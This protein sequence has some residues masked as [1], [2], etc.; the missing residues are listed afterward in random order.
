MCITYWQAWERNYVDKD[1]TEVF[2]F[3]VDKTLAGNRRRSRQLSE[4][5][6]MS[7]HLQASAVRTLADNKRTA[8]RL[9]AVSAC[10]D[11][12]FWILEAV[13]P[14]AKAPSGFETK[15][16]Q[17]ISADCTQDPTKTVEW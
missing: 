13:K 1:G 8:A 6:G 3:H 7:Q 17:F 16:P 4:G 15:Y 10:A 12:T 14:S 9:Q 5:H 2:L 11:E